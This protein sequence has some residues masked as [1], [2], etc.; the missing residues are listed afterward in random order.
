MVASTVANLAAQAAQVAQVETAR[1]EVPPTKVA[2]ASTCSPAAEEAR[3]AVVKQDD[4]ELLYCPVT[5]TSRTRPYTVNDESIELR[6]VHT[7]SKTLLTHPR[8]ETDPKPPHSLTPPSRRTR[9]YK[10]G[11]G[12]CSYNMVQL[13]F[14]NQ[15]TNGQ[16]DVVEASEVHPSKWH[17]DEE[18]QGEWNPSS[19]SPPRHRA[20]D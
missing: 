12:K 16:V 13:N 14:L 8:S 5:T 20:S 6:C 9:A 11:K 2:N 17:D 15:L 4:D 3:E 19:S 1:D 18:N 7:I 10:L